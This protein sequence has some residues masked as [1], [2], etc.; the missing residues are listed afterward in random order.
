M[1]KEKRSTKAIM[2]HKGKKLQDFPQLLQYWHPQKNGALQPSNLTAASAKKVWWKCPKGSDHEWQSPICRMRQSNVLKKGSGCPFCAG[3]AQSET[4][5]LD[6]LAPH[7][8]KEWDFEKNPRPPSQYVLGSA[9]KVWWK[10]S[11]GPD[12]EWQVSILRRAIGGYGCPFCHNNRVSVTN[13][14]DMVAPLLIPDW[15]FERNRPLLPNQVTSRA[16]RKVWWRCSKGP[17][18]VWTCP[19]VNRVDGYGC[20][21]CSRHRV[22]VTNSL[23]SLKPEVAKRWHPTKNGKLKPSDFTVGSHKRVWWKCP[24]G[25]DHEWEAA[26]YSRSAG[27]G[28]PFCGTSTKR[29]SVTNSLA[30][31]APH[32]I[33]EWHPTKNGHVRPQDVT[34]RSGFKAW[35]KCPKGPDHEWKA[36]VTCRTGHF[37]SGCPF[38]VGKQVSVTNSLA[39][40]FPR[41]AAQWHPTKNGDLRP[42]QIVGGSTRVAHWLCEL[43][44][45]WDSRIVQRTY[46]NRRCPHCKLRKRI[47]AMT[48]IRRK[49]VY[50][51]LYE[52]VRAGPVKRIR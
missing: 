1:T 15:D 17:D 46:K 12:H 49:P 27:Q 40:R 19:I 50:V 20:P 39:T 36:R 47:A 3:R 25:P 28:C 30:T 35:W 43:G 14:L 22:S 34:F 52:G 41:I 2:S 33:C 9:K 29:A 13:R 21:F 37:F 44:H 38:C 6:K 26:I 24:N 32:L 51:P 7:L 11:K 31:L 48:G 4:N 45:A 5:R 18:H 16:T 10:C 8:M 42:D 23:A